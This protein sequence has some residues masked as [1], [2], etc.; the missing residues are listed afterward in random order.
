MFV[1]A[2]RIIFN[3]TAYPTSPPSC[4]PPPPFPKAIQNLH[5]SVRYPD[6]AR[7][8]SM[9]SCVNWYQLVMNCFL[10]VCDD[11]PYKKELPRVGTTTGMTTATTTS[12]PQHKQSMPPATASTMASNLGEATIVDSLLSLG[13][14]IFNPK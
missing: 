7:K 2:V 9:V 4:T 10:G 12:Q 11:V 8:G 14:T 13:Y 3:P 5:G 6:L 1:F